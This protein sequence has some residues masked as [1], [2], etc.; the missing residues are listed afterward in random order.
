VS[1][2][3]GSA[4]M[5]WYEVVMPS[6]Q[7]GSPDAYFPL[8]EAIT[9]FLSTSSEVG[10]YLAYI[11]G[12]ALLVSFVRPAQFLKKLAP[13]GRMAFTNYILQY[14][15]P[16]ILFLLL[17]GWWLPGITPGEMALKVTVGFI[18]IV[19]ISTWW[20]KRFRF[21]PFEWLWRSLTYWKFQPMRVE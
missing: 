10:L 5:L 8:L 9:P 2:L 20:L 17:F 21:G 15:L 4:D 7:A 6:A 12:F 1:I 19:L 18:P 14:L 16:P 13:T 3:F 11:S